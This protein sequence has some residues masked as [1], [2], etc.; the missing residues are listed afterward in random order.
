MDAEAAIPRSG[1]AKLL[2]SL[3]QYFIPFHGR[4]IFHRVDI[5]QL[6]YHSSADEYLGCFHLLAIVNNAAM[7]IGV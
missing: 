1:L 6:V 5:P 3:H 7:D 2:T 4:I